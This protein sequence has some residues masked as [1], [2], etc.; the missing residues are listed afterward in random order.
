MKWVERSSV[1][2]N[3]DVCE[4]APSIIYIFVRTTTVEKMQDLDSILKGIK[5]LNRESKEVEYKSIA[6][7]ER[8]KLLREKQRRKRENERKRFLELTP[9]ER[10]KYAR[11]APPKRKRPCTEL[12]MSCLRNMERRSRSVVLLSEDED[13]CKDVFTHAQIID[14]EMSRAK[15]QTFE[16][17]DYRSKIEAQ[18]A[19]FFSIVGIEFEYEPGTWTLPDSRYCPDF[20]LH[21]Q[22]CFV[23]IKNYGS[24][25]PTHEERR[26]AFELALATQKPVF[27]FFG[28][29]SK[30]QFLRSGSAFGYFPNGSVGMQY[31]FGRCP[32][33]LRID[34]THRGNTEDMMCSCEITRQE[35][36]DDVFLTNGLSQAARYKFF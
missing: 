13:F 15:P 14:V 33:C 30:A 20:Y 34:I 1:S 26:K 36:Y 5:S 11:V 17:I 27:I 32:R 12:V 10:E 23:E 2:S 6:E 24:A 28:P 21:D 7:R 31:W 25:P 29:L 18:W 19:V 8:Q 9:Q 3:R 16:G 22:K 4:R 35:T